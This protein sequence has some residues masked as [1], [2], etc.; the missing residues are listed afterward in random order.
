VVD[1]LL[2]FQLRGVDVAQAYPRRQRP[3]TEAE[4]GTPLL[5]HADNFRVIT[6]IPANIQVK[7]ALVA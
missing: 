1:A 7:P 3:L 6:V 5:D 4:C 2:R